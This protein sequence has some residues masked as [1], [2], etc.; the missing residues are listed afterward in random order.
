MKA[1]ATTRSTLQKA[2]ALIGYTTAGGLMALGLFLLLVGVQYTGVSMGMTERWVTYEPSPFGWVPLILGMVALLGFALD[3]FVLV[4][5]AVGAMLL[6]GVPLMF[7]VGIPL[8][9]GAVLLAGAALVARR[10][11][12]RPP[13]EQ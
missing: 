3:R 4:W 1:R 12:F 5:S 7:N 10:P 13:A 8:M 6:A 2:A 11:A 9:L